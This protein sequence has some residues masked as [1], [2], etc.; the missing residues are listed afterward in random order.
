MLASILLKRLLKCYLHHIFFKK[1][2]RYKRFPLNFAKFSEESSF[3]FIFSLFRQ[4]EYGMHVGKFTKFYT[5]IKE[6]LSVKCQFCITS[7]DIH[8]TG[9]H[10]KAS[11][12]KSHSD[13]ILTYSVYVGIPI[14]VSGSVTNCLISIFYNTYFIIRKLIFCHT[15][16]AVRVSTLS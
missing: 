16:V 11:F 6:N 5:R 3:F 12:L 14:F 1:S 10:L 7:K 4:M 13:S 2:L 9:S 15:L 8:L